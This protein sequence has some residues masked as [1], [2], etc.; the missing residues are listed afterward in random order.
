[1]SNILAA[2]NTVFKKGKPLAN[3]LG[4]YSTPGTSSTPTQQP[5]PGKVL[6]PGESATTP[7]LATPAKSVAQ[8]TPTASV[9]GYKRPAAT[10][11]S[12]LSGIYKSVFDQQTAQV[13]RQNALRSGA[14][15][16]TAQ[17]QAAIGGY[18][19]DQTQRLMERNAAGANTANLE[20]QQ[21]LLNTGSSLAQQQKSDDLQ[22]AYKMI[23]LGQSMNSPD[24]VSASVNS[25]V[26]GTPADYSAVFG[27]DGN[28]KTMSAFDETLAAQTELEQKL[29]DP[30][31]TT[32][33][34]ALIK[35]QW[36]TTQSSAKAASATANI[37]NVA[38][39]IKTG[40]KP[41]GSFTDA[42]IAEAYQVDETIK[43]QL[44]AGAPDAGKGGR[45]AVNAINEAGTGGIVV[46]NG[47]PVRVVGDWK[48][49]AT[50]DKSGSRVY[51][52]TVYNF[53][54]GQKEEVTY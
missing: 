27:S 34:K 18:N 52:I 31:L 20:S 26:S 5:S 32:E 45:Q 39:A 14:A 9:T 11:N 16:R 49:R 7:V 19:P 54:T 8:A 13:N 38:T 22:N 6:T 2:Y 17:E 51:T 1:M 10:S 21:D 41:I 12:N 15:T 33:Q 28:L 23:E 47:S 43:T 50:R 35:S 53:A 42:Q 44:A 40:T 36:D 4:A 30:N 3:G 25:L 37:Q 24:L 46:L 48:R 29:A